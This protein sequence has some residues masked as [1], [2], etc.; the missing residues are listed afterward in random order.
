[1]A[2]KIIVILITILFLLRG[3][4]CVFNRPPETNS[5]Q[6]GWTYTADT[7]IFELDLGATEEDLFVS[8]VG[9]SLLV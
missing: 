6:A 8:C 7:T 9:G 2:N 3:N 4:Q 1:M 5:S